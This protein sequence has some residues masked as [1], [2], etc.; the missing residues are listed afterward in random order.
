MEMID[1]YHDGIAECSDI[2]KELTELKGCT[3][4]TIISSRSP[5]ELYELTSIGKYD[6][7]YTLTTEYSNKLMKATKHRKLAFNKS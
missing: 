6:Y 3:P 7:F 1:F 4:N 5:E 2:I